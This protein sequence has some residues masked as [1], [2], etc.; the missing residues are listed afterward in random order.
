M[1]YLTDENIPIQNH[2]MVENLVNKEKW[3]I[4]YLSLMKMIYTIS[5]LLTMIVKL[6]LIIFSFRQVKE[7][8]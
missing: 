7:F 5:P 6:N 3:F 4:N 2:R 1:S 8:V